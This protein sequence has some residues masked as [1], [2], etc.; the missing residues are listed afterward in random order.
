M[1]MVEVLFL[2][3]VNQ[4]GLGVGGG[5]L[6]VDILSH[7]VALRELSENT[8]RKKEEKG[9]KKQKKPVGGVCWAGM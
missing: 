3:V 7:G 1:L 9:T 6:Q 8:D 5:G 4:K 2:M